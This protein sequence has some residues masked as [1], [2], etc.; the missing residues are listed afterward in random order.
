M[1]GLLVDIR[2]NFTKERKGEV[3]MKKVLPLTQW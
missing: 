2:N 1:P 3:I